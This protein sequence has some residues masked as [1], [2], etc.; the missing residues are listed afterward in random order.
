MRRS[1]LFVVFLMILVLSTLPGG[2]TR[3]QVG[4]TNL[5]LDVPE[6]EF[7]LELLV[8]GNAALFVVPEVSQGTDLNGDADTSDFV[9]HVFDI[10]TGTATNLGLA[11]SNPRDLRKLQESLEPG[12]TLLPFH[13]DE[14]SQGADLNGD[15]DMSDFVVHVFNTTTGITTT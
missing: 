13:V 10:T 8:G 15:A 2:A 4:P 14:S 12:K 1:L 11:I 3:A 9:V 7:D 5:G 6:R